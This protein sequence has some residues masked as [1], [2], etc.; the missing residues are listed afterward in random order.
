M[1]G[2]IILPEPPVKI[3]REQRS[4]SGFVDDAAPK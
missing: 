1:G 3:E 4:M 2:L